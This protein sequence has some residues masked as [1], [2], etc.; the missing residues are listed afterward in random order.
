MTHDSALLPAP[1][2]DLRDGSNSRKVFIKTYGCQMNVYD[3]T[4]MSD[5]LARD[6]YEPT[7]DMEEADLVLLNTCHI[8][9]KAAEKVYSAL[10]RLRDMKKKR[11]SE[12]REFMIGVA[13]CVAQAEGEEILRRAP[14]VDVVIGPQTYHRLPEALRRAKEG[15]RIVDTEYAL[16]DKFEHLPI[17]DR[18]RIRSRGV[19]AF[20]TV[21]EGCDKFCTFCVVPYTRGSE[22]SRGTEPVPT[23]KSGRLATCSIGSRKSPALRV[24]AIRPAIRATWTTALSR[25]IATCAR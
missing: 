21:Q 24:C 16:E 11:T 14:A 4:R 8:R 2:T 3:S 7:E 19:T 6:G 23:V 15:Q 20:L 1:E 12:G 13:G 22:V 18:N 17:A 25:R 9:E 5:A 10:G